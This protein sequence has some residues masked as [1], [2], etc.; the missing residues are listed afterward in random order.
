M[1]KLAIQT[2]ESMTTA[3]R[4][5]ALEERVKELESKL[6]SQEENSK[7]LEEML[8]SQER[9]MEFLYGEVQ[10]GSSARDE[11]HERV[12]LAQNQSEEALDKCAVLMR[13]VGREGG[14]YS[15]PKIKPPKPR[16]FG[17]ARDSKEVDNFIF[18]ME[19]YFRVCQLDDSL[20]VDTATMYL[21]DDAK[22]W[23]R[24]KFADIVAK[25]LV[26][27]TWE[28]F[29]SELMGHF[30][31]ENTE[32]MARERLATLQHTGTIREYIKEYM[33]CMLEI[34]TMSEEDRVY[35]FVHG[36]KDWAKRELLRQKVDTLK[37][38]VNTAE[39]LTDYNKERSST[40]RR[41]TSSSL[42]NTSRTSSG[43]T[44]TS[45][46]S[47]GNRPQNRVENTRKS[48]SSWSNNSYN[49]RSSQAVSSSGPRPPLS[50]FICKGPHRMADC[51]H[52]G[53]ME[54]FQKRLAGM[55]GEPST[56]VDNENSESN[57][58]E[59]IAQLGAVHLLYSMGQE[60]LQPENR[61]NHI[62]LMY[63]DVTINGKATRAMVDTGATHNF[64]TEGEARR[65]GLKYKKE[66]GSMK[67]VNSSAKPIFGVARNIHTT[68]GDWKGQVNFTVAAMDD[69]DLVFGMDF[70][71][72]SKAIPLPHLK[73]LLVAGERPC[74]LRTSPTTRVETK[75]GPHLSAMQL[76]KG[77]KRNEPTFL[78]TLSTKED[79]AS[80]EVPPSLD[81]LLE[82]FKD[83][84]PAELPKVLPPRRAIDHE[85]SLIPGARPPARGAYRMA[86]PEL[87]E[88]RRQLDELLDAGFIR[89]SKAPYG[90][91]VL[92]QKKQDGSLRLCIDYRALNK[93][94]VKNH[95]P[96]P[97][98]ADL[99]DQLGDATYFTKLDLRSGYHQVRIAAG[100]EEKTACVTRYGAFD[101][102]VMPFG[103]TNAPATFCTLMNQVFQEYLDKFVVVYLDDI[104]IY[105]KTLEEHQKHLRKV[106][107]KLREHHLFVKREKCAFAQQEIG[108]LGHIVGAGKIRMDPKKIQAIRDWPS[109]KNI[110]ELRSFLGLVNYY[111]RFIKGYSG[112]ASL[113]T[114]LLKKESPWKW[115]SSHQGVFQALKDVVM[116][117]P[118]LSL[119]DV[120]KPFEVETDASDFALGGVLLQDGHPVAFES[121]KLNGAE[122]K[123]AAQE[124][125]LLAIVHCLRGWRHYLLGSKFIVRTDNTAASHFLTQPKLTGRQARWQE[126][127]AEFDVE[128]LHKSGASNRVADALSRRADLASIQ[129][130]NTLTSSDIQTSI[131]DR[132]R[133]HLKEDPLASTLKQT[134]DQGKT[135][136]F[137]VEDGLI[138]TKGNRLFIPRAGG[139]RKTLMKEC[140]DTL[141]AGHPGWQRTLSLLSQ[142]YYWPK[143]KEDVMTY[144]KTCLLCQQD[145]TE[146]LKPGG[147]LEPLPIPTRPW[148]SVSMDF[149][150]GLPK[151][152]DLSGIMVVIDR[153]SKYAT[154]VPTS[155]AF[156]AEETAALFFKHVVKYWGLP[157]SI[158][159]DRDSRFTSI[160]WSELFQMLGSKLCMSS[161]LHPQ[162]DGQTERFNGLLEEYLRHFVSANQKDWVHLLDVAQLC[163]N[164]RKSSA[165]NRSPFEIVTG[166][167]PI[168][169]HTIEHHVEGRNRKVQDFTKEWQ[170][171]T[172]IA[173]AYLE[174]ASNR[175]K[176]WADHN[177]RPVEFEVGDLV[178]VK[179]LPEQLRFLRNR[180]KRLLRKYEGPIRIIKR[181]GK[182]A[183][184]VDPPTWL[185]VHPV[186]HSSRLKP[187]YPDQLDEVRNTSNRPIL[188][189]NG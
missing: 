134:I 41:P 32:Y 71:E 16:T 17:G 121:R 105:S 94:T 124:K 36:L 51:R 107:V 85:I 125:E 45:S 149:I 2:F 91:P 49:N 133:Q 50:C 6:T 89:P 10:A 108:F 160:F 101:W 186:F 27:D 21:V 174:K 62:N 159:S 148:E 43:G 99:F 20:K 144:T 138:F 58:E 4:L 74:L 84:M 98:I 164:A 117:E 81:P 83:L 132:V 11:L 77:V 9:Q 8:L 170:Q 180:D 63:I 3:H 90:A 66:S 166:Q 35:N 18:D 172:E 102:L 23:W 65:L 87:K 109:P 15:G 163:F 37:D 177:R 123:Y 39:R 86:P 34:K 73:S 110:T 100:D 68:L 141:W 135:R 88:L 131:R 75:R 185:K 60:E 33:A 114:D 120:R 183:Y 14:G 48:T 115:L 130:C 113:L 116:S 143:M 167:Q 155:K 92:F 162:T 187:Y 147:L 30:Y 7:K 80:S 12:S 182:N 126:A 157:K 165:S 136:R 168:L 78:A 5:E 150:N 145:K 54:S 154:F 93:V 38:A 19:Q 118:V 53:E 112:K 97:L 13:S 173:R 106:F 25:K 139:L 61:A 82:E 111:R 176:K 42:P 103:L 153:F 67:T 129:R 104:V 169:P 189:F 56:D 188:K 179:I 156:G 151:V 178:M 79:E 1:I 140:H 152:D 161:S 47:V 40:Q 181:I 26:I 57:E 46:N 95:Y 142:G 59:E 44:Q 146:R 122:R 184:K 128:F 96:I 52:K 55:S 127:L 24:T 22:L 158:I 28:E 64:V 119:P 137:W 31:P 72:H 171:N 70:L 76:K 69:F 29:K 175:M